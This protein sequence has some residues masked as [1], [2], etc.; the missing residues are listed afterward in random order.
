MILP[1]SFIKLLEHE[2]ER[3]FHRFTESSGTSVT[4][5]HQETLAGFKEDWCYMYS[6]K[7]CFVCMMDRPQHHLNCGHLI[8]DKCVERVGVEVDG[9]IG[10]HRCALCDRDTSGFRLRKPP[11]TAT[12]RI[13]SIDGGGVR[14]VI[15]LVFLRA[16]EGAIGLQHPVQENFD[17][18]VGTS[19]G[20]SALSWEISVLR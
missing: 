17:L 15:P 11:P 19:S 5:L 9:T 18:I 16:L 13:L 2:F 4:V 3:Q 20:R 6:E 8:C 10:I 7:T 14:G 1:S 12:A